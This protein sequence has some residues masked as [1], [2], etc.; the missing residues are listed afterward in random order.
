MSLL[1]GFP[2]H[3]HFEGSKT[4]AKRQIG[5]AWGPPGSKAHT[6]ISAQTLEGFDLGLVQAED[7]VFDLY[8]HL[9]EKSLPD[10]TIYLYQLKKTVVP[11]IKHSL[12]KAIKITRRCTTSHHRW[13]VQEEAR[14]AAVGGQIIGVD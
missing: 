8:E 7:E 13:T 4:H 9:L 3:Y 2:I 11:R 12:W 6:L 5:N 10:A 1:Q 14:N